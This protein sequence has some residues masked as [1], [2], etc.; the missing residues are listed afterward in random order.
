MPVDYKNEYRKLYAQNRSQ[1]RELLSVGDRDLEYK[2]NNFCDLHGFNKSKLIDDLRTNEHLRAFFAKDPKKQNIYEKIAAQYIE[3]L[4]GVSHFEKLPQKALYICNGG[5]LNEDAKR[6]TGVNTTA[7]TIDFKWTFCDKAFYASHKYTEQEGGAQGNQYKDLKAFI[8]E[9]NKTTLKNTCFIAIADGEFY[10]GNN[11]QAG[12]TRIESLKREA[13]SNKGV[14]ACRIC[15][16]VDVMNS[17]CN[18]NLK[19]GSA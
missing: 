10:D 9:A 15:D 17:A 14:Y 19:D 16:L 4:E 6:K 11:G 2:I 13:N 8:N 5:I 3:S 1:V 18:M 7:K 12:M